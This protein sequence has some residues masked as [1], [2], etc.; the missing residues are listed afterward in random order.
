METISTLDFSK[1]KN[2]EHVSF[3][4]NVVVAIEKAVP[5][6]VGLT[7]ERLLSFKNIVDTEQDIVNST[8]ASTYTTEMKAMDEERDRLFRLIRLKLEA[9]TFASKDSDVVQFAT[10]VEK[11]LLAK[12]GI[13]IIKMAYQEES[14][15]LRGFILDLK[16]R[17][18]EDAMD[19]MGITST[20]EEL[21]YANNQFIDQYNERVNEKSVAVAEN[22]KKCRKASEDAFD[23]LSLMF[24]FKG[25]TEPETE[26]GKA[27][28]SMIAVINTLIKDARTRLNVRLGKA[29]E[30][31]GNVTPPYQ[32]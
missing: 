18:D 30:E 28:L 19:A 15:V 11:Y 6:K 12:Y 20:L 23:M 32:K 2:A 3:F 22:T 4:N 17:F 8:T 14:A 16:A 26:V 27:C 21:E 24:E 25:N 7:T 5:T 31:E 10:T 9:V 13:E 29:E 1:L